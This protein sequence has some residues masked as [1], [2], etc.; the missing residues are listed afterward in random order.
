MPT[1][2]TFDSFRAEWLRDIETGSPTTVQL[3]NRFAQKLLSNWL[4]LDD[5][6]A[7]ILYCDGAG[8]G[9]IDV[10][11]LEQGEHTDP[12]TDTAVEGD[13][14]YL[15]QSKYGSAFRGLNTLLEEGRKVID[16]LSDHRA[17]LSSLSQQL[18][19]RLT[20]FRS[21][22][23]ANDRIVLIFAT[24]AQLS[25]EEKRA[26]DD[27]RVL[28]RNRL[29][30]VFDVM[31]VSI[32]TIYQR[33]IEENPEPLVVNLQ[34]AMVPSSA[35][36]LVGTVCLTNLYAFLKQY[37]QATGDLD[38]IYDK[39][40]RR[41][42]GGRRRVNRGISDT[43]K[44]NPQQFGLFNNGIT[45]VVAD[46]EENSDGSLSLMNP[47]I[48]NG[49][50]TTRSIWEVFQSR[51]DAGGTG[52]SQEL[53]TWRQNADCG[54]LVTKIVRVG[55]DGE[56]L[57]GD[58]TRYT[59]SQNAITDK[60]FLALQDDFRRWKHEMAQQHEI[61][62]EIQ[63]GGWDSYRVQQRLRP[64]A[65]PLTKHANAFDLLKVYGAGWLG[66]AGTAFGRNAAF[67]PNGTVYKR[68]M[69]QRA[70]QRTLNVDDL[71]AAYLLQQSADSYQF[72]RGAPVLMRRQTRYLFYLVAIDILR[73]ILRRHNNREPKLPEL[74]DALLCLYRNASSAHLELL[75]NAIQ[76]VDEYMT[77]DSEDSIFSE[78]ALTDRF[79]HDVNGFLKWEQ[80]GK[81]DSTPRLRGILSAYQ[82]V[83]GRATGASRS[84]RDIVTQA[85]YG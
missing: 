32:Y 2:L 77:A 50:Q 18:L 33:V 82:R 20:N 22:A 11:F 37:K 35:D 59:N 10:A 7:D 64:L 48:V 43:L 67:L 53:Q 40:V 25:D 78:P 79:N 45:I 31:A 3:G 56:Q 65:N 74:T 51:L 47:Y 85:I 46:F 27:V 69:E 39:N 41:F 38:Q 58:I 73:D 23:S 75:N 68:I 34:A 16:T 9:G 14:W 57:L 8:D 15:V 17:Q 21:Q 66:D 80:L 28:G 63:R 26:L 44:Q 5:I 1:E 84:P 13:A 55:E 19:E 52:H 71:Y 4:E 81:S 24:E 70:D 61:Y 60:D 42:L 29:G 12:S 83:M 54:V 6:S 49:C 62:L 36:L 76:V 30:D 72:G